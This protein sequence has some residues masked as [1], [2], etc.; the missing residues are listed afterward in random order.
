[1]KI[2]EI[3]YTLCLVYIETFR[4]FEE[5]INDTDMKNLRLN[6]S[7]IYNQ[8]H[9]SKYWRDVEC[10]VQTVELL[11]W[12]SN[13]PLFVLSGL[14]VKSHDPKEVGQKIDIHIQTYSFWLK[15]DI[16]K[17]KYSIV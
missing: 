8:N 13:H 5:Q 10:D 1:L 16:E 2:F 9:T 7:S 3:F 17:G 12:S 4:I 14:I 11:T 6:F 15:N